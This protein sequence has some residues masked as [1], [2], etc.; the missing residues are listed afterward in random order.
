MTIKGRTKWAE[1]QVTDWFQLGPGSRGCQHCRLASG[2]LLES[3]GVRVVD[4]K[5]RTA[6]RS[7]AI[8]AITGDRRRQA[9]RRARRRS[10]R[11]G[12]EVERAGGA[13]GGGT[14]AG[15]QVRS[16]NHHLIEGET[17]GGHRSR[18]GDG[19]RACAGTGTEAGY[20]G[21]PLTLL[22]DWLPPAGVTGGS[23]FC[24][25]I[26]V[27]G[28]RPV[29]DGSP[30][31]SGGSALTGSPASFLPAGGRCP[32][33]T[34]GRTERRAVDRGL[35]EDPPDLFL[36][37]LFEDFHLRLERL[38][39]SL[40]LIVQAL[41]D[42]LLLGRRRPWRI[43]GLRPD[44]DLPLPPLVAAVGAGL[45]PPAAEDLGGRPISLWSRFIL[46]LHDID[47]GLRSRSQAPL[48]RAACS[49][50][51]AS[52]RGP[53]SPRGSEAVLLLG[54]PAGGSPLETPDGPPG[55][56]GGSKFTSPVADTDPRSIRI[57]LARR[58]FPSFKNIST[59]RHPRRGTRMDRPPD[60]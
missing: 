20:P 7:G 41:D 27:E 11:P 37:L 50:S 60:T 44:E 15:S 34:Q 42:R 57:F 54:G 53:S 55:W 14:A 2:A 16:E 4:G 59:H 45:P 43:R 6:A 25:G 51:R 18:L 26:S 9:G 39:R 1:L 5:A 38:H 56:A 33:T 28:E 40:E 19:N 30:G 8:A 58:Y 23:A 13:R 29:S 22:L 46:K 10:S 49:A 32:W 24:A 52:G 12:M 21:A 48:F 35:L 3:S 47:P 36:M 31:V 17:G